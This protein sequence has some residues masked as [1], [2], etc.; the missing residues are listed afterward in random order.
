MNTPTTTAANFEIV[1]GN[2]GGAVLQRHDGAVAIRYSDMEHL[3]YD[4]KAID[5]GD[6]T[7]GWDGIET[8]LFISDD[9]Y[10]KHARNNGLFALQLDPD[11]RH[12]WPDADDASWNNVAEFIRAFSA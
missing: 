5:N 12:N 8:E 4:A 3:A 9:E 2:G 11:Y 6:S 1:F 7:A 10:D